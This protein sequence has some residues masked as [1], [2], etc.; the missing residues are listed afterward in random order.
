VLVS[1][2]LVLPLLALCTS[3]LF[4]DRS[5]VPREL[6]F[7]GGL[8]LMSVVYRLV[9]TGAVT[10]HIGSGI[11]TFTVAVPFKAV[12]ALPGIFDWLALGMALAVVSAAL[13]G[14]A[15]RPW[16]VEL[17]ERRPAI[18]W[19]AA[20]ALFAGACVWLFPEFPQR[21]TRAE[22]FLGQAIYG[23]IALLLLLPAV[24]DGGRGL[25]RRVLGNRVLAWLGLTSYGL[26]LWHGLILTELGKRQLGPLSD[27]PGLVLTAIGFAITLACA[28]ASYYALERPLLRRSR[29]A[30][31]AGPERQR[32]SRPLHKP[33]TTRSQP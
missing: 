10:P 29:R 5:R 12:S 27:A 2:Y 15:R 19:L 28:T 4:A 32:T 25:P 20:L 3:R 9:V 21:L 14:R 11:E 31:A 23:V 16:L 18:C 24:F 6:V 13:E 33:I 17:I 26:Y 30:T 8:Y 1:F 22:W 7:I